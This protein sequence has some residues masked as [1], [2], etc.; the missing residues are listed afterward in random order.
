[1]SEAPLYP[2]RSSH[3]PQQP[4]GRGISHA[5]RDPDPGTK[6][7]TGSAEGPTVRSVVGGWA[8]P[9]PRFGSGKTSRSRRAAEA[10]RCP[11]APRPTCARNRL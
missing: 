3:Q 8:V 7:G 11:A 1:M 4:R 10:D 2:C 6:P 9:V 5:A